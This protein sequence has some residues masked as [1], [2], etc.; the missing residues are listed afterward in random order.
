MELL[1]CFCGPVLR[2]FRIYYTSFL[3]LSYFYY[4]LF[5]FVH[6]LDFNS[7]IPRRI[8]PSHDDKLLLR[9]SE[10]YFSNS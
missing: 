2:I 6:N 3:L 1:F 7:A 8:L 9:T 10:L 4:I 5:L